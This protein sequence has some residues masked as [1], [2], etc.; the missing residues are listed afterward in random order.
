MLPLPGDQKCVA[1]SHCF[2]KLNTTCRLHCPHCR[3]RLELNG[4]EVTDVSP[5]AALP[6]LEVLDLRESRGVASLAPVDHV[7]CVYW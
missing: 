2:Q 3:H 6:A 7:P 5:L 1:E 4:C